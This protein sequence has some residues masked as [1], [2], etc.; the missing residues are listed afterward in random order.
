M[1]YTQDMPS[2]LL[3]PT[4]FRLEAELMDGLR[5]IRVRDGIPLSEQVRRAIQTW[6]KAKGVTVELDH[7]NGRR[8]HRSK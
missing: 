6:L 3:G 8:R 5:S 2:R 7:T 4:T 1:H